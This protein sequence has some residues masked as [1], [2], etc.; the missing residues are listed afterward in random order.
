ML[1]N[2]TT[3]QLRWPQSVLAA[4]WQHGELAEVLRHSATRY[5]L[6]DTLLGEQ[7]G[8]SIGAFYHYPVH[9]ALISLVRGTQAFYNQE[10][11]SVL[12]GAYE[13]APDSKV[14]Q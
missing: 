2:P 14:A 10:E 6:P 13:S 1:S 9:W 11:G 12:Y 3:S 4:A 7:K 5:P 8:A